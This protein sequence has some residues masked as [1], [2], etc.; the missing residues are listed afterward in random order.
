MPTSSAGP[1]VPRF[2]SATCRPGCATRC[3]W[4]RR[5]TADSNRADAG[6]RSAPPSIHSAPTWRSA[7][8]SCA[9]GRSIRRSG[10]SARSASTARRRSSFSAALLA[11]GHEGRWVEECARRALHPGK[12]AHHEISAAGTSP[13]RARHWRGAQPEPGA[14][15]CLGPSTLALAR[16]QRGGAALSCAS[17]AGAVGAV[18][19]GSQARER[20]ARP[21][22]A[23]R[24]LSNARAPFLRPRD[25][26]CR[27]SLIRPFWE[28]TGSRLERLKAAQRR[29]PRWRATPRALRVG[30]SAGE[31]RGVYRPL[32]ILRYGSQPRMALRCVLQQGAETAARVRRRALAQVPNEATLHVVPPSSREPSYRFFPRMDGGF[33][34]SSRT[35][36]SPSRRWQTIRPTWFS[37]QARRSLPSS[38]LFSSRGAFGVPLVLDYRDEWTECPFE[39]VRTDRD[40]RAWERRCLRVRM[41][42]CSPP[43]RTCAISSRR[44]PS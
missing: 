17:H 33:T 8:A 2:G 44:S 36:A 40:D 18:G 25:P 39:Y 20:C 3:R 38:P 16:G 7:P 21:P 11:S 23:A 15:S 37:P 9:S 13:A 4:S 31:Q 34:N 10:P 30:A 5:R 22:L 35:R 24:A 12:A 27:H 6:R 29:E 41:R 14:R 32:S 19:G 1:I 28:P 42:C 26:C 43:S